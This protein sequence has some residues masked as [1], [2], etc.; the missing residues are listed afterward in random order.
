MPR[1]PCHVCLCHATCACVHAMCAC[2]P[3]RVGE[4]DDSLFYHYYSTPTIVTLCSVWQ[5]KI[6]SIC[7]LPRRR[8]DALFDMAS[9]LGAWVVRLIDPYGHHSDS[10]VP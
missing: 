2:V 4:V 5:Y 3:I 7:A 6:E 1:Q 8:I 9:K 10:M